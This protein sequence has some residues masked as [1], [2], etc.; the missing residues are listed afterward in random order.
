MKYGLDLETGINNLKA[1]VEELMNSLT[2]DI[3]YSEEE[4]RP[5]V[6]YEEKYEVSNYGN[7]RSLLSNKLRKIQTDR[8]GYLRVLLYNDGHAKLEQV[9]RLVA[10]AFIPNIDN[11]PCVN[12]LDENRRNKNTENLQWCTVKENN[13]Y[14]NRNKKTSITRLDLRTKINRIPVD[15]FDMNDNYI[16][17]FPSIEY[18]GKT[19]RPESRFTHIGEVCRGKAN[20]WSGFKW[21]FATEEHIKEIQKKID[22]GELTNYNTSDWCTNKLSLRQNTY[23]SKGK[24]NNINS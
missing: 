18:A 13:D 20:S 7:I 16:C 8:D 22:S 2:D 11:K 3:I 19:I 9:H 10:E 1:Q 6:G 5:V 24:F 15:C 12:H 21:K 14:G 23:K 4:W 17:T